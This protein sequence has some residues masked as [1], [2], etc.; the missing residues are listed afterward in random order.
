MSAADWI[1]VVAIVISLETLL[2]SILLQLQLLNRQIT[3][4]N[5]SKLAHKYC[6]IIVCLSCWYSSRMPQPPIQAHSIF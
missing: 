5:I 1:A 2:V 3:R 4:S 6:A